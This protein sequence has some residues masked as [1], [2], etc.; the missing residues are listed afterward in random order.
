[1]R[2][3]GTTRFAAIRPHQRLVLTPEGCGPGERYSGTV[4]RKAADRAVIR[5]QWLCVPSM[6]KA[7]HQPLNKPGVSTGPNGVAWS[8]GQGGAEFITMDGYPYNWPGADVNGGN[9]LFYDK[10]ANAFHLYFIDFKQLGKQSVFRAS[11]SDLSTFHYDKVV[12]P[13]PGR[14]V[15]DVK[16][17]NGYYLMGLHA[18]SQRTWFSAS[19]DPS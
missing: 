17:V 14:I 11:S 12:L 18:N 2:G 1:M 16:W 5:D 6:G 15:N 13:E 3:M 7:P 9:V 8:P 19:R 4:V 10:G